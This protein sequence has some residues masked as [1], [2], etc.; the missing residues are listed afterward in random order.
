MKYTNWNNF[1]WVRQGSLSCFPIQTTRG[2]CMRRWMA[3]PSLLF[4]ETV[5]WGLPGNPSC[6]SGSTSQHRYWDA[7]AAKSGWHK[8]KG[9]AND[10]LE[11][12]LCWVSATECLVPPRGG[13]FTPLAL[14]A[15]AGHMTWPGLRCKTNFCR[16][17]TPIHTSSYEPSFE[18]S[19]HLATIPPIY[20]YIYIYT[21]IYI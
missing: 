18:I 1:S 3:L 10:M 19:N 20:I 2:S 15:R 13:G 14:A 9:N 12:Y 8:M 4:I 7:S 17:L 6:P 21:Y 11:W 16:S 5:C